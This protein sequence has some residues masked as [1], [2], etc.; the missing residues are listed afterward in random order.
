[1]ALLCR[2]SFL[3]S[4][5]PTSSQS[6]EQQCRNEFLEPHQAFLRNEDIQNPALV[7][8]LLR[9]GRNDQLIE[10]HVVDAVHLAPCPWR[11]R[12]GVTATAPRSP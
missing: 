2:T 4:K 7:W 9:L 8:I 11:S 1:M 12:R 6:L 10:R 5:G 3:I